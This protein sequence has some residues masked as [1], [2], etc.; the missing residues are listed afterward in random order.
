VV[1]IERPSDGQWR[2]AGYGPTLDGEVELEL[3]VTDGSCYALA[4]DDFGVEF[5]ASLDVIAGQRIRP[6]QYQ[7]WLYEITEPG[8]L[9]VAEPQWWA[10]Q[11]DNATRTLGTARA[12]AVRY[13]RPLA[14]GPIPVEII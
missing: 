9:P 10:A 5:A 7:G 13:Y 12:L 4:L 1:V 14:H 2:I 11:G 8:Q 6:T 3:K